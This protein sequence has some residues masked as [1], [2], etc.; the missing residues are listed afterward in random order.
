MSKEKNARFMVRLPQTLRKKLKLE[1]VK[2]GMPMNDIIIT[3][4]ENQVG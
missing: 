1:S 3:L 4:I 2:T